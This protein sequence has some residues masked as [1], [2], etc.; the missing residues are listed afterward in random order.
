[1]PALIDQWGR[2]YRKGVGD[3]KPSPQLQ[4]SE[5]LWLKY[6]KSGK[7]LWNSQHWMREP[8]HYKRLDTPNLAQKCFER[9]IL[10]NELGIFDDPAF[11]LQRVRIMHNGFAELFSRTDMW[12][13]ILCVFEQASATVADPRS[14]LKQIVHAASTIDSLCTL[15]RLSPLREQIKGNEAVFLKVQLQVLKRFK[16]KLDAHHA[17]G[18]GAS[19]GFFR[20]PCSVAN[21]S[22]VFLRQ[23]D[24]KKYEGIVP[25][26]KR[27]R[28]PRKQDAEDL[29][30][31]LNMIIMDLDTTNDV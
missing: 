22:L 3:E 1:V 23:T 18:I 25:R 27:V 26:I 16:A 28:F 9:T 15:C 11:G 31:Y 8:D 5:D 2:D 29:R 4:E 19:I 14:D 21:M 7:S 13:G 17:K 30:A 6:K 10:C 20:E 24:P 12:K